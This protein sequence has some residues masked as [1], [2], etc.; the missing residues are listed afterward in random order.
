MF[1]SSVLV[2]I[3]VKGVVLFGP[4]VSDDICNLIPYRLLNY[5][6]FDYMHL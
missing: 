5:K 3:V 6:D 1:V 4:S 2:M